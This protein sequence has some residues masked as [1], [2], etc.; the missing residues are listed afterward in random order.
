[1]SLLGKLFS[2]TP[3]AAAG[4]PGT[5]NAEAAAGRAHRPAFEAARKTSRE[6]EIRE[7]PDGETLRQLA[8]LTTGT[9][10]DVTQDVTQHVT[11]GVPP[12][13]ERAARAR[14]ATLI[15][16]GHI[17]FDALCGEV[18]QPS[19]L[20]GVAVLCQDARRLSQAWGLIDDPAEYGRLA[21]TAS[22]SRVRQLAADAVHD[23]RE[24]RE[25]LKQVRHKDKAVYKIVKQKCDAL[26]AAERQVADWVA[27]SHAACEALERHS[28]R[29]H[30][31]LYGPILEHLIVRWQALAP[32]PDAALEARAG[33]AIARCRE[34]LDSHAREA[35]LQAA[36]AASARADEAARQRAADEEAAA[37][38]AQAETALEGQRQREA[39]AAAAAAQAA[40]QRTAAE[41]AMRQIGGL[42]HR[43]LGELKD[44]HTQRAAG[45]RRAIEDKLRALP[46]LPAHLLRQLQ[47]L[48]ERLDELKLWKEHAVAPKRMA[49]ISAMEGLIG[50]PEAPTQLAERVRALRQEWRTISLGIGSESAEDWERFDRAAEAA[51]QPCRVHFE[52]QANQRRENLEKRQA[53]L[54]RLAAFERT[55][56]AEEIDWRLMA[57]V[58][59]EAAAEWRGCFPVERLP[60]RP[61]Q[62]AFEAALARLQGRLDAWHARN[63]ADK[64]S[65]ITRAKHLLTL[66]DSREAIE[67]VKRLQAEWKQVAP[68]QREQEQ[69][70]WGEFKDVCDRVYQKR[71]QAFA[72]HTATL[73]TNKARALALCEQIEAIAGRTGAELAAGIAGLPALQEEYQALSELPATAARGLHE[74]FE[75]ALRSCDARLAHQRAQEVALSVSNFVDAGAHIQAY[76]WAAAQRHDEAGIDRLRLTAE[77]FVAAV[78]RWPKG[79]LAV[80]KEALAKAGTAAAG[81]VGAAE[82]ALRLLCI[83]S[84][85]QCDL[86]TPSEDDSLRREY[87]VQ[88]LMQ[89]LGQGARASDGE[90]QALLLEWVRHGPIAPDVYEHLSRRFKHTLSRRPDP[91]SERPPVS[92]GA[93]DADLRTR[94]RRDGLEG[95][96]GRDGRDARGNGRTGRPSRMR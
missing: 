5:A 25:L 74:R 33:A 88:R 17:D 8:G 91:S 15:D 65:L 70:L 2:K 29:F 45:L 80:I 95:R 49:L 44:G 96:H 31:A 7:M 76:A 16:A 72:D 57:R 23:P 22:S 20:L 11:P 94:D 43:A 1:M 81:D 54:E 38:R 69:S 10:P 14:L 73:A 92:G 75:R 82:R 55:Q 27:E 50:S 51:Y 46:N 60:N 66:E 37:A 52:A 53:L 86:P 90:W 58:V 77:A 64:Q 13:V 24:L 39:D 61:L 89:S 4:D 71:Q 6:I 62:A 67:A 26:N 30:D 83:R 21:L 35:L 9:P 85:I 59:K 63:A 56:T 19:A 87:Q 28:H 47:Q 68:A 41:Q 48:D 12:E 93:R 84:E 78:P 18:R 36:R 79:G 40:S 42:I 3:A 32:R 34:V